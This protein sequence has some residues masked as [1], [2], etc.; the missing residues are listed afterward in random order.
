MGQSPWRL[1]SVSHG[2]VTALAAGLLVSL[3]AA[4]CVTPIQQW[5]CGS[6]LSNYARMRAE[7]LVKGFPWVLRATF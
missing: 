1:P 3:L 6:D 2:R 5:E 4:G 7:W